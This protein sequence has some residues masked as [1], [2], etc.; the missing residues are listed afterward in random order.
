MTEG[1]V[2]NEYIHG[3][4]LFLVEFTTAA[5]MTNNEVTTRALNFPFRVIDFYAVQTAAGGAADTGTLKAVAVDGTTERTISD[6]LDLN[7]SDK[8]ITRAGTLDDAAWNIATGEYL[9]VETA[10]DAIAK[11]F[12]VCA[13]IN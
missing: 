11:F 8:V 4:S 7:K 5:S 3:S 2:N 13:K 12:A 1:T 10:S 6:A 9:R